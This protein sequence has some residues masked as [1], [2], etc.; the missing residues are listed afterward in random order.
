MSPVRRLHIARALL[1]IGGLAIRFWTQSLIGSK[2]PP[3]GGGGIG[4]AIHTW[5]A[6]WNAWLNSHPSHANALLIGCSA[7][8]DAFGVFLI[9]D[10][11]FWE[12]CPAIRRARHALRTAPAAPFN[13]AS[14]SGADLPLQKNGATEA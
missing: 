10:A 9:C 2:A 14:P 11:V 4:D 8:I 5:T 12:Q 1:V 6:P 7:V 13:R 3:S